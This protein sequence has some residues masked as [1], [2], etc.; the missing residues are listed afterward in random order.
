M[1]DHKSNNRNT[2]DQPTNKQHQQEESKVPFYPFTEEEIAKIKDP[3][4]PVHSVPLEKREKW[5]AK[6]IN[7]VLRAEMDERR[8]Q[9]GGFW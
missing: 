5:R 6:G 7:P 2:E 8:R 3:D 4:H 1:G 9:N